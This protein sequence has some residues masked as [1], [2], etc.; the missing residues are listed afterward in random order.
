M[1]ITPKSHHS[2]TVATF[3]TR[4]ILYYFIAIQIIIASDTELM[5]L[6][7]RAE[8]MGICW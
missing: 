6:S 1:Y 8:P 5:G 4:I 3:Y 2:D 7:D